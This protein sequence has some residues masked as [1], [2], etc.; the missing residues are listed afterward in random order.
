M[1]TD[2]FATWF[3]DSTPYINAHR[4]RTF[5]VLLPGEALIEDSASGVLHDIVHDLALV[6]VLGVRLVLV[7]GARC[8]IDAALM[9]PGAE[10]TAHSTEHAS[11]HHS[12]QSAK[13]A[14]HRNR[15]VTRPEDIDAI[16]A[17]HGQLRSRIESIFS[18]GLPNTPLHNTN[19]SVVGGNYVVA[20]PLGVVDGVDYQLTGTTRSLRREA[21]NK[22]LND[23]AIVL[24]SPIGYSPSGQIF[25]LQSEELAA[26][27]AIRLSADKLILFDDHECLTTAQGAAL[28]EVTPSQLDQ[29]MDETD[30][31]APL[32][33]RMLALSRAARAGVPRGHL[34]GFREN[35]SLLKELY[36]APG[37]GTQV[38]DELFQN[39]RPAR[40]EDLSAIVE[41]IRPLE[42]SG[43]LLRRSRDLLEQQLMNFL[44]AEIDQIVVGCC[45]LVPLSDSEKGELACLVC[46]PSYRKS[47]TRS[48]SGFN[49]GLGTKL[50]MAAEQAART[51]HMK[52]LFVLTT[53]SRDW[54]IEHG[55]SDTTPEKLPRDK[56]ALYNLQRNSKVLIKHLQ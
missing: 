15:R 10:S 3:R 47:A 6:S 14:L 54:F 36:T 55:F 12:L 56:Q 37:C 50:L 13:R 9:A 23:G 5:V 1:N 53:Q 33:Q 17:V 21:L 51:Q 43:V 26:D 32:Y 19:L 38:S 34:I 29:L 35:G 8:Q 48:G 46:H 20:R 11:R 16:T 44:V 7:H 31:N 49:T 52:Q 28:S 41:L 27:I 4:N 45:A 25:N 2:Q 30:Q 22:A 24:L 40:E 42:E 39:I 18:M